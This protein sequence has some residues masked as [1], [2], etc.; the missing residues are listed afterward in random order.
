MLQEH[1]GI[2]LSLS[3]RSLESKIMRR[4]IFLL[5]ITCKREGHQLK[6]LLRFKNNNHSNQVKGQSMEVKPICR[7]TYSRGPPKSVD[8]GIRK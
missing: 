2:D 4:L 7:V 5:Q 6:D 8:D 3:L 1:S